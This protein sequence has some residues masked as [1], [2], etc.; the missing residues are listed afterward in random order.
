M[1]GPWI[2]D[3][4]ELW[5]WRKFLKAPW[6]ARKS[7]QSILKE[8]NTEYS[9]ERL[10]LKLKFQYSGYLTW[11]ADSLEEILTLGKTEGR[12][13]RGCWR[14]RWLNGIT[15]AMHKNLA[16]LR[17]MVKDR[18]AWRAA[19]HGIAKSQTRLGNWTT[20]T[21]SL[22]GDIPQLDLSW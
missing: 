2:T 11:T 3:A 9:L 16:K 10:M 6:T 8:I 15:N 22:N 13:R 17:E 12:R 4:F 5:Y 18:E 7:N 20:T 21:T 1:A 19:A 14:T